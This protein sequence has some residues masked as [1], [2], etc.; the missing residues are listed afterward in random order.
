[1]QIGFDA[2]RLFHNSTGLG[3]YSRTLVQ[4]LYEY[5][6][7]CEYHLFSPTISNQYFNANAFHKHTSQK[8]FGALWRS[9][10]MSKDWEQ[11]GLQIY[12]G[13]SNELPFSNKG[14]TKTV[15]TIHD[16][17]FEILPAT[18]RWAD[19]KIYRQK[20]VN[21]CQYA[22][23]IVAISERTKSD[24]CYYYDI[25]PEKIKVI[26]QAVNHSYYQDNKQENISLPIETDQLSSLPSSYIL[27]VGTFQARKNQIS[28]LKAWRALPKAHQIPIV[29]V[30]RGAAH[31][32]LLHEYAT[33]YQIPLYCF[34][35]I[36]ETSELQAIYQ[37]ASVFVFPSYY[38]GFGLPII[39][40]L[41]SGVPVVCSD[42]SAMPEAAG[43]AAILID[44]SDAEAIAAGISKVLEDSILRQD[45]IDR[46]R[47]Y[48][49]N[50]FD[51]KGL[52]KQLMSLYK[53]ML[54]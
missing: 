23:Q 35:N 25:K 28:I 32:K 27:S 44:P 33:V 3:N 2:K 15:V 6:P 40:A 1:M 54:G 34:N 43:D 46:G 8:G 10:S 29:L 36:T 48:A 4:N 21:S 47:T 18:Y 50:T 11:A 51:R 30:G 14:K 42:T 19:R 5:F 31:E 26:Y 38:E 52:S 9:W 39:E 53:G 24:I 45:M 49:L 7:Q 12:H 16:L 41:L 17:I 37:K 20:T 22:D 13:L